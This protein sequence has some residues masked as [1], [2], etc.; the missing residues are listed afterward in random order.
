LVIFFNGTFFQ[1][2]SQN[3]SCHSSTINLEVDQKEESDPEGFD[4]SPINIR[5]QDLERNNLLDNDINDSE[6]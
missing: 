4:A 1:N 6:R 3:T 5:Q 2:F